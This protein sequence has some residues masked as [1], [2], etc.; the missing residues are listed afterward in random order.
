MKKFVIE[1]SAEVEK[2]LEENAKAKNISIEKMI[3]AILSQ[4]LISPHILDS[5][6]IQKAYAECG[7]LNL[8]W[9]NL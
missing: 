9:A 2:L 3:S 8:D 7:S 1:V 4:Y 5:E 6:D